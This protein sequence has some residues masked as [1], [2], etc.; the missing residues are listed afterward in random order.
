MGPDQPSR[1]YYEQVTRTL[2]GI[3]IY[4]LDKKTD[5]IKNINVDIVSEMSTT[6]LCA[7]QCLKFLREQQFFKDIDKFK[8]CVWCDT[9]PHFRNST[10]AYYF[11]KELVNEP[12]PIVVNLNFFVEKHGK[13]NLDAHFSVISILK[14]IFKK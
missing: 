12:I 6:G 8:Y 1:D 11:F 5:E 2:F 14:K 10:I 9:G 7:V 4:Y 3:G 13:N